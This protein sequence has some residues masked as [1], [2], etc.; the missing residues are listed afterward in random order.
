MKT[1]NEIRI[2]R[3]ELQKELLA[4][5][6]ERGHDLEVMKTSG[7]IIALEWVLEGKV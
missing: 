7:K 4:W 1:E 6:S 2:Q 5:A 3:Q